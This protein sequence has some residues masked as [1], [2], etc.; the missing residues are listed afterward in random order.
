MTGSGLCTCSELQCSTIQSAAFT[1][2][3]Y[4][5]TKKKESRVYSPKVQIPVD[6]ERTECKIHTRP[7]SLHEK[8]Q[9]HRDLDRH[10]FGP[11]WI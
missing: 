9:I 5:S 1:D 6:L 3:C 11:F 10:F 8:S 2:E 4:W 7:V